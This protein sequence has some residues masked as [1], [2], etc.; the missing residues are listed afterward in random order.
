MIW[1]GN[2]RYY[3]A[4]E[5]LIERNSLLWTEVFVSSAQ[6]LSPVCP[7]RLGL[8]LPFV[9]PWT[10][11]PFPSESDS[12]L[13][14]LDHSAPSQG[15]RWR[16]S[17]TFAE[18]LGDL[19]AAV[20]INH[21]QRKLMNNMFLDFKYHFCKWMS[22]SAF[23]FQLVFLWTLPSIFHYSQLFSMFQYENLVI[24]KNIID[25]AH[26]LTQRF[27]KYMCLHTD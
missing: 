2:Y 26:V 23:P 11:S 19:Y 17:T 8:C 3:G 6:A 16:P 20:G 12:D 21:G 15:E 13:K 25:L 22:L 24:T 5:V 9:R 27:A 4:T 1:F 10:C 7:L 18:Q 14:Q